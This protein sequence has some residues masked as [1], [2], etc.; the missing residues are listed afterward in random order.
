MEGSQPYLAPGPVVAT[1]PTGSVL[2]TTIVITAHHKGHIEM[3]LCPDGD[4]P[5]TQTCLNSYSLAVVPVVEAD[6]SVT[7]VDPLHPERW[8]LPP[9]PTSTSGTYVTSTYTASFQLPPGLVCT[10]CVIQVRVLGRCAP[11][12]PTPPHHTHTHTHTH[13]N[14]LGTPFWVRLGRWS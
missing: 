5:L 8:Y 11:A 12:P 14:A 4:S 9:A 7:P 1:L 3:W 6:G 13:T 10:H 2:Q